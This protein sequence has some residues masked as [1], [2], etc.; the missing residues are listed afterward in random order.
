MMKFRDQR[1]C[2]QAVAAR[3]TP[4]SYSHRQGYPKCL[5]FSVWIHPI[6]KA[7]KAGKRNLIQ[8][9]AGNRICEG[10]LQLQPSHLQLLQAI[11]WDN[12]YG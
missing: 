5:N 3:Q 1:S 12:C 7:G 6:R 11:R 2:I 8:G 10:G 9:G 4:P